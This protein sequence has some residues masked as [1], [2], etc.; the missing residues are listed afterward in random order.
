VAARS[1]VRSRLGFGCRPPA[2]VV[3][4]LGDLRGHGESYSGLIVRLAA[5]D[6]PAMD[7]K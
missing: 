1:K 2:L 3:K 6:W 4:R 7:L 5:G